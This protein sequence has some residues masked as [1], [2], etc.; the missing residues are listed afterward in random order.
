MSV[1]TQLTQGTRNATKCNKGGKDIIRMH[2][3][4]AA[5]YK[6]VTDMLKCSYTAN[7]KILYKLVHFSE[8][9]IGYLAFQFHAL[10]RFFPL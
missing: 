2:T 8:I 1:A 7:K 3:S 9:F 4:D 5:K 6:H 10:L